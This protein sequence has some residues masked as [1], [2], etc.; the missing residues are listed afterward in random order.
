MTPR[1]NCVQPDP[2]AGLRGLHRGRL[3]REEHPL[4]EPTEDQRKKVEIM[5][6]LGIRAIALTSTRWDRG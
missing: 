1:M 3:W 5:V 2:I 6:G 4:F